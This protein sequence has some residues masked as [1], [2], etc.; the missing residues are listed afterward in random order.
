M[1]S[2]VSI[3]IP[4]FNCPYVDQAIISALNQTYSNI[5]IIV[6]DD[7]STMHTDK[8]IPFRERVYYLG[9]S[10]GGTASALNHGIRH[11]S[12]DYVAWLSSDDI[13]KPDKVEKQLAFM[14]ANLAMISYTAFDEIN[15]DT[16]LLNCSAGKR[17]R[18]YIDFVKSWLQTDPINGCTVMMHK[19]IFSLVGYFD[20]AMLYTHDYDLWLR[21]LL[22]RVPIHFLDDSLTLYRWHEQMGTKKYWP[23]IENEIQFTKTKYRE[24]LLALIAE[25]GG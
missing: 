21:I 13:F 6:V 2:K 12:G 18:T 3:I 8:I 20:E 17:F 9:K 1:Q 24:Q 19:Q 23:A 4:F 10:N 11:A 14:Q 7:G 5:E 15:A 16:Q 25:M 22:N